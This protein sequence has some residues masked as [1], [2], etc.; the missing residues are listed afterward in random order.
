MRSR[1]LHIL[2]ALGLLLVLGPTPFP[3]ALVDDLRAAVTALQA[4]RPDLALPALTAVL[5]REP[6]LLALHSQT[7]EAAL[8]AGDTDLAQAFLELQPDPPICEE[9]ELTIQLG[10]VEAAAVALEQADHVCPEQLADLQL[11]AQEL[12]SA[13]EF[14]EAE[15]LLRLLATIQPSDADAQLALGML[16][17]TRD[18]EGALSYLQLAS[19][20]GTEREDLARALIEVIEGAR[21][22]V[23]AAYSL[24]QVGQLYSRRGE[25]RLAV[26]AFEQALEIEPGYTEARAYLGLALDQ[27]GGDGL[28]YLEQAIAEA[29][30][31]PLPLVLL[32]KHWRGRNDPQLALAAFERAAE[33]D[34]QDPT[35]ALDLGLA[36]SA[37]GEVE[38]AKSAFLHAVQLEPQD[39][40]TWQLLS[41][42]SLDQEIELETLALPAARR[43]VFLDP[44]RSSALDALGYSHFLAGDWILADR[45]LN[46]AIGA[47]MPAPAAYYHLGILRLTLGD[48]A[49]GKE[50]L[51]RALALDP[52]GYIGNLAARSIENL[53]Q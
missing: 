16:I 7:I 8:R 4:R 9:I 43:A 28:V 26:Q 5:D 44:D 41:Q 38:A 1:I 42:F 48:T 20:M 3:R 34:P 29:P 22:Q 36:Y 11:S 2:L 39:P 18:P 25:W 46:L 14:Q 35:I 10:Q 24:A 37:V 15:A 45:F 23:D 19:E 13:G 40:I 31:A 17:V 51:N 52:E 50:A 47:D 33:L 53:D 27:S 32:G 30:D 6:G 12:L 21:E 49:A